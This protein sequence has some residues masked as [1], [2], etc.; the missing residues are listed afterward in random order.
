MGDTIDRDKVIQHLEDSVKFFKNRV[1]G[2]KFAAWMGATR[3]AI[4]LLEALPPKHIHEEYPEHDWYKNED[5]S[6]NDCAMDCDTHRGPVCKRCGESFCIF[7]EPNGFETHKPCVI[8]E[9]VCPECGNEVFN[10]QKYCA[11]CGRAV[12]WE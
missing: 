6:I 8:D 4:K 2:V 3:D 7:C 9:F 12:K 11:K 5:G 10:G 1:N